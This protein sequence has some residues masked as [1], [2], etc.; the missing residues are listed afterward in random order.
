MVRLEA[1]RLVGLAMMALWGCSSSSS[2][3]KA[4]P[5]CG[6]QLVG[7]WSATNQSVPPRP[8]KNVDACWNLML[9]SNAD[10]TIAASSRYDIPNTSDAQFT[11]NADGS[12]Y[13]GITRHGD[14]TMSYGAACLE[15]ITPKPTCD[16]LAPALALTG[17]GEG[18]VTGVTCVQNS[19]SGCD[20]TFA[21]SETG[22]PAGTWST[23]GSK[24][25]LARS[26]AEPSNP[27]D[28]GTYCIQGG[29]L[30]FSSELDEHFYGISH[31]TFRPV[32]Q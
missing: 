28:D 17:L 25:T 20:C 26:S 1:I 3:E 27:T 32:V 2:D 31:M 23:S 15:T 14:V 6:G 21:V 12:F 4:E 13:A 10:G 16:Q 11:F 8:L 24:L 18:S 9:S 7:T 30:R 19:G 5:A 29:E 22:G